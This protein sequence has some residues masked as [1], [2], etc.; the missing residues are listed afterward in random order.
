M[1]YA[2]LLVSFVIPSS[3]LSCNA[4]NLENVQHQLTYSGSSQKYTEQIIIVID[5]IYRY[6]PLMNVYI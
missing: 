5:D 3:T 4:L 2:Y 1:Q 6:A